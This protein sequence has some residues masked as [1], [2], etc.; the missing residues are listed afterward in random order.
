MSHFPGLV[1]M[2]QDYAKDKSFEDSIE[3]YSESMECEPYVNGIVSDYDKVVFLEN[4]NTINSDDLMKE[5]VLTNKHFNPLKCDKDEIG[6]FT[7]NHASE[8]AKFFIDRN[9]DLFNDFEK[10]YEKYGI[11]W[12]NYRW[13]K[14]GDGVWESWS[15]SNPNAKYDWFLLGG[16]WERAIKTN[17]NQYV[18]DCYLEEIDWTDD[19]GDRYHYTKN[20]V[21]WCLVI[22]GVWYERDEYMPAGNNKHKKGKEAWNDIFMGLIENLPGDCLVSNVDFHI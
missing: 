22:D 8:Y 16:N 3:E 18:D 20:D 2:T 9:A 15:E 6:I 1:I 19:G 4:Y 14:N 12:N 21:P 17:D 7:F 5:F 11:D 10:Q 13:R